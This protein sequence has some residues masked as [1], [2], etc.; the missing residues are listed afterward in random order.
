MPSIFTAATDDLLL[1]LDK[2]LAIYPL[3]RCSC[4]EALKMEYFS[5]K[6]APTQGHKLPL[7]SFVG[8]GESDDEHEAKPSASLKRKLESLSEGLPKKRLLF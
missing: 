6:P 4:T 8:R 5:N 1:L 3:N 2:L 7:P